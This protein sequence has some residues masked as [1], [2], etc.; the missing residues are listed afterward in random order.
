MGGLWLNS[1]L[2]LV[3]GPETLPIPNP[4]GPSMTQRP[5]NLLFYIL[6]ATTWFPHKVLKTVQQD[7]PP[8]AL[9]PLVVSPSLCL[10]QAGG[11]RGWQRQTPKTGVQRRPTPGLTTPRYQRDCYTDYSFGRGSYIWYNTLGLL[12]AK[13]KPGAIHC[14][15]QLQPALIALASER[16]CGDSHRPHKDW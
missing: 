3:S 12:S 14:A 5:Q 8:V 7:S 4:W 15:T 6:A 9:C 13:R 10:Q 16:G 2:K 1:F 11:I